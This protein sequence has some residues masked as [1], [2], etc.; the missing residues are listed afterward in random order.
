MSDVRAKCGWHL[1]QAGVNNDDK[2]QSAHWYGHS[3]AQHRKAEP[4]FSSLYKNR[5]GSKI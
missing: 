2:V 5:G 3:I 4:A 1:W